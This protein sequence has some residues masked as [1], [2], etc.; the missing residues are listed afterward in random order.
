MTNL[1]IITFPPVGNEAD[2]IRWALT[3]RAAAVA[4]RGIRTEREMFIPFQ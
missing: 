2:L 4:W 1:V 3:R